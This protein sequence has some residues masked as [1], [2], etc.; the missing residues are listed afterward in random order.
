[1]GIKINFI[2]LAAFLVNKKYSYFDK[3]R[4]NNIKIFSNTTKLLKVTEN[5]NVTNNIQKVEDK[6]RAK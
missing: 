5:K 3:S 2:L 6:E 4:F 1:M